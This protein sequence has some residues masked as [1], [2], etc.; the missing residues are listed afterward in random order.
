M[1]LKLAKSKFVHLVTLIVFQLAIY[2]LTMPRNLSW[3]A[4]GNASDG[5]ELITAVNYLGVPHPPGY[6]TYIILLKIF[7]SIIPFGNLA[8]KSNL[9]SVLT[10]ITAISI[11]FLFTFKLS[12]NFL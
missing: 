5:G 1:F 10:S 6:P 8:L 2:L 7:T 3:G 9:F 12:E 4:Y 11:I